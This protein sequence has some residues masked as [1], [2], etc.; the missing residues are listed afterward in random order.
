M[1]RYPFAPSRLGVFALGLLISVLLAAGCRQEAAVPPAEVIRPVRYEV[2]V[3]AGGGQERTFVGTAQAGLESKLSFK[4]AGT[5]E[6]LAVKVGERVKKGQLL[7]SLDA[8]D[9]E[10]QVQQADAALAQASAEERNAAR[11]YDRVRQLYE[12]NNAS[13]NDLDGAR[14]GAES[15]GAAVQSAARQL[16]LARR[17]L[18]Y[19]RLTTPFDCAVASVDVE[20]RENVRAGQ[21]VVR[22]NCGDQ[23]EVEVAVPESLIT[24]IRP[25]DEVTVRFDALPGRS[26]A[27]AVNEVGIATGRSTTTYPVTVGLREADPAILPGMAAEVVFHLDRGAETGGVLV[28]PAAV[29]EDRDGRFVFVVE[30]TGEGL[31]VAH[32]RPVTVG[33]LRGDH[34]TVLDGLAPGEKVVTAGVSRI[35][36]GQTVRLP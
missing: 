30:A 14:A 20:E 8:R 19:T 23:P 17:Q 1:D 36:D 15:A 34:L 25:G 27:A 32:R 33:E 35:T 16:E 4:V 11:N 18:S 9:Y 13:R 12:N 22:V 29:G 24:Q 2:V 6:R 7:A 26:F 21:T 31:A 3:A 28:A 10:L 5:V